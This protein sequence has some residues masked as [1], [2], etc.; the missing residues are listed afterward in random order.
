MFGTE[1]LS[2]R[3][4]SQNENVRVRTKA[5]RTTFWRRRTPMVTTNP[6]RPTI[7]PTSTLSTPWRWRPSTATPWHPHGMVEPVGEQ[8]EQ[9]P[10]HRTEERHDP[11]AF[12]EALA[13]QEGEPPGH[14]VSLRPGATPP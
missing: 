13:E 10:Q 12:L 2:T 9:R 11:Q 3:R 6:S 1:L 7:A 14:R 8:P 4:S 5:A